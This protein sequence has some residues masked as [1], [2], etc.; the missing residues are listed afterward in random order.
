MT[1]RFRWEHDD[2][3]VD[4]TDDKVSIDIE[5]HKFWGFECTLREYLDPTSAAGKNTRENVE[6]Y[7]T[8]EMAAEIE[9]EVRRRINSSAG[10]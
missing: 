3:A 6:F 4:V 8:A 10:D 5:R 7:M 1:Q 2:C 9:A